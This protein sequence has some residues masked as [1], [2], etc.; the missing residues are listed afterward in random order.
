M[1]PINVSDYEALAA[2]RV[3]PIAWDYYRGGAEDEVSLRANRSA[4]ERIRLRPRMLVDVSARELG[5]TVLGTPVSMPILVAPTAYHCMACD[6][7]ECATAQAA[8]AAGT[9]MVISTL[10]TRSIEEVARAAT[11]PLWF[12]LYV[13]RDRSVSESLVHRA[14]A[15]GCKALVLTVDAPRLGTRERDVRNGFG[16]P[17]HLRM[18]NF[19]DDTYGDVHAQGQ[20]ESALAVHAAA[21]FDT[22]LTWEGL[23]WL[24]SVTTL[25]VLVK[26]ILTAEDAELAVAH[27]ADGI[28]VS[29][30]GGRQLD[31]VPATIE[32]LPEVT[33]AVAGRC[34]LYL[35]GGVRRGTDVLKALALGARAVLVGRP[36]IWGLATDGAAGARH[37]LELLRDELDLAMM[38]SGR[39]TLASIDRALVKLPADW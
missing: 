4:F 21:L 1:Q 6:E 15:V 11:G 37:V 29:N 18:A 20:G 2:A 28:I 23:E 10:A 24:R 7:G 3:D 35:D 12:Q 22:S 8:G 33:A 17:P 39:P 38:L 19:V 5:T 9:V 13:Y 36:V 32:A 27:G 31:G 30:H 26:G 16:L 14:E 34:E 25:P